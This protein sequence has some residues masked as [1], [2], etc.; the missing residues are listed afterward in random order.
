MIRVGNEDESVA[1][2]V[3]PKMKT[4]EQPLFYDRMCLTRVLYT[5]SSDEC[6]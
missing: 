5:N 1:T 6:Y 4:P 3:A 2:P